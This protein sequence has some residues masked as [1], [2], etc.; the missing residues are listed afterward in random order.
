MEQ[1]KQKEI[2][3]YFLKK[4]ILLSKGFLDSLTE[5]F[6]PNSLNKS[7]SQNLKSKIFLFLSSDVK[8]MIDKQ[9]SMDLNWHDFDKARVLL[10]K[11]KNKDLYFK[12]V[13]FLDSE[14]IA[15][16]SSKYPVNIVFSYK[17]ESKKRN[18]QDFVAYFNARYRALEAILRN[19]QELQHL[20]SIAR[21]KNKR[22]KE[23]VSI[24]GM[25]RD[26]KTTSKGG[27]MLTVEDPTGWIKVYINNNKPELFNPAKDI[28]LD[29]VIGII[30]VNG[31]RIVF[32]NNIIWPDVPLNKE[33]K[34]SPDEAYAVFLSDLHVGSDNFLPT[35][36]N[37]FLEWINGNVGSE[38]QREIAKTVRYVFIV[39]DLVDGMG[40][41]PGQEDELTIKD[42]KEQYKECANLLKKIP[43]HIKLIICPG[44]HDAM[45]I[46]EPQPELYKD[47]AE[48]IW[49][50]PNATMVSNPA[51]LNIHSSEGFP[52]F[53]VLMYHGYSFDH[54]VANVDSIRNQGGYDRADLIMQFLLQK[55]HL[56]PTHTSTLYIPDVKQD[57]LV[58]EK[59]PDIFLT[60]HIHKSTIKN[61]RNITL[62]CG[63][64]WQAKTPF[65]EKVGHNPEPARVPV[66]NLQTRNFK[67][68]K[69]GK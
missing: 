9:A 27:M 33:L 5:D 46:A 30:G 51:I 37:Q 32:A 21:L 43:S 38:E 48:N 7:L 56:A 44:N 34:K 52:G 26:K 20:T 57:S 65:Q 31:E 59:L 17:E 64:C 4:E 58:I 25:V 13:E 35:E 53:D 29:E 40:I 15:S 55:R 18:I 50:L 63:S 1:E 10:E 45:R 12:F 24:I 62:V 42:I 39:G 14:E 60:G 66:L 47:F 69:F 22:D 28:V 54:F 41:Y 36:F 8:K 19:R 23:T 11:G 61:Y 6:N 68:L 67:L 49:E 16:D 3:K 2:I